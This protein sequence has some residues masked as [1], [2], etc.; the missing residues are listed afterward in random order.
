MEIVLSKR[1]K[2]Q[3][4]YQIKLIQNKNITVQQ[5][6]YY[7]S[8]IKKLKMIEINNCEKPFYI[9]INVFVN[10]PLEFIPA[11]IIDIIKEYYSNSNT[12]TFLC[13]FNY[14]DHK[15]IEI[16]LIHKMYDD[17]TIQSLIT[18]SK[19]KILQ[20]LCAFSK[21]ASKYINKSSAP[22]H[23]FEY[24]YPPPND[25]I[26]PI[27]IKTFITGYE[28]TNLLS[29]INRFMLDTYNIHDFLNVYIVRPSYVESI[30]DNKFISHF[31]ELNTDCCGVPG[32]DDITENIQITNKII[33]ECYARIIKEILILIKSTY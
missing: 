23:T 4:L 19:N 21:K 24:K 8:T 2:E 27:N 3:L 29:L 28:K 30:G 20:T 13:K 18:G 15:S 10:I 7:T 31:Y 1:G 12:I 5:N 22:R 26:L 25:N 33:F 14:N 11:C 17:C 6:L 9:K 16:K 32:E